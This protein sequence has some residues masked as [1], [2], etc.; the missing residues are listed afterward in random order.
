MVRTPEQGLDFLVF[1]SNP[2]PKYVMYGF[3]FDILIFKFQ[4]YWEPKLAVG[5]DYELTFSSIYCYLAYRLQELI[6]C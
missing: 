1:S 4:E 5:K 6:L 2:T 3:V